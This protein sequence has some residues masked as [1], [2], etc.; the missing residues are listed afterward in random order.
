M[1]AIARER[2]SRFT[3]DEMAT[4]TERIYRQLAAG[5]LA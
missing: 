5:E 2:A 3:W 1:G 4:A